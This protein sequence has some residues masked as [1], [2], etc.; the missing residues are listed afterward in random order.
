MLHENPRVVALVVDALVIQARV[1][2]MKAE[3]AHRAVTTGGVSYG[4][5]AFCS[6]ADELV[7]IANALRQV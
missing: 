3:N 6:A 1:E 7:G 2:G 5:D 4:E